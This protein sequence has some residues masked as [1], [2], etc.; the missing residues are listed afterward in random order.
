MGMKTTQERTKFYFYFLDFTPV[1]PVHK[2]KKKKKLQNRELSSRA[3]W[4]I[5]RPAEKWKDKDFLESFEHKALVV[6][7]VLVI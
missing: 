6:D 4:I 3:L 7:S 2:N 5:H 1:S